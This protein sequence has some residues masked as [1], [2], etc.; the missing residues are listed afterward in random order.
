[1]MVMIGLAYDGD[2]DGDDGGDGDDD[3]MEERHTQLYPF[4]TTKCVSLYIC[5]YMLVKRAS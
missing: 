4:E 1:M 2:F 3:D 5:L